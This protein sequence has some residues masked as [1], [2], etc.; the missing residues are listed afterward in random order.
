[1]TARQKWGVFLVAFPIPTLIGVFILF[2][3]LSVVFSSVGGGGVVI[4]VANIV[5]ILLGLLGI[6][7]V[8]GLIIGTPIGIYLLVSGAPPQ[9]S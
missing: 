6:L 1:M 8:L 5:R 4:I 3:V 9:K 2:A 7:S